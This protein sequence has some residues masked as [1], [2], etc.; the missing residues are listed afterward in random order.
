MYRVQLATTGKPESVVE[1]V[2]AINGQ[3]VAAVAEAIA[4]GIRLS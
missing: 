1:G 4:T 2:R 3:D